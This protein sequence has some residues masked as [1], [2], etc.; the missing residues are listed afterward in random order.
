M[1]LPILHVARSL[2]STMRTTSTVAFL[3]WPHNTAV[4]AR[5]PT[6]VKG[7]NNAPVPAMNVGSTLRH[8]LNNRRR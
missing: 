8:I 3:S 7:L 1:P 5:T 2:L 4:A 6:V